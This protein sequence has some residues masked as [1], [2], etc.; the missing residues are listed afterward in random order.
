MG[1]RGVGVGAIAVRLFCDADG[2][3]AAAGEEVFSAGLDAAAM[4]ARGVGDGASVVRLFRDAGDGGVAAGEEV[5][6]DDFDAA[7]MG[8][9]GVGVGASAVRF[10]GDGV[11]AV[12]AAG[13]E[14]SGG[15]AAGGRASTGRGVGVGAS[16]FADLA[17]GVGEAG[18]RSPGARVSEVR[19]FARRG[20]GVGGGVCDF[21]HSSRFIGS[22]PRSPLAC[23]VVSPRDKATGIESAAANA[24]RKRKVPED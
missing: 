5:F 17:V 8:V 14:T 2:G 10:L 19:K 18:M 6:S 7:A 16:S 3:G 21:S 13:A 20:A 9:R 23:V 24:I 4:G 22:L 12:R 15:A 11:E 1:A